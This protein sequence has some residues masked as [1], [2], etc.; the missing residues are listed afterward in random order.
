VA[1]RVDHPNALLVVILVTIAVTS[2][3]VTS[4]LLG[5][6]EA[7]PCD[8]ALGRARIYLAS[9]APPPLDAVREWERVQLLVDDVAGTCSVEVASTFERTEFN[10]WS[11]PVLRS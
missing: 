6:G 4:R 3:F 7:D 8:V 9:K 1:R 10:P 5:Q 2:A 11:S